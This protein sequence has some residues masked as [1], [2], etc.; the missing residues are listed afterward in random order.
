[1]LSSHQK[2]TIGWLFGAIFTAGCLA[3]ATH[4]WE[5]GEVLPR[6]PA[7]LAAQFL[8]PQKALDKKQILG[9]VKAHDLHKQGKGSSMLTVEIAPVAAGADATS[10][11]ELEAKVQALQDIDG[12]EYTWLLPDGVTAVGGA[13]E[14]TLGT[15]ANGAET[16]LRLSVIS[17]SA[18]NKQIHLHVFKRVNGEAMGQMAQYN[19]VSQPKIDAALKNKAD[20]LGQREADGQEEKMVQ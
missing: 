9:E 3:T 13:V 12:L 7:S 5:T 17:S 20:M 15:L 11:L 18:D 1:M 19:T 4:Y 2:E 14:G 8:E 16:K 6:G 10:A